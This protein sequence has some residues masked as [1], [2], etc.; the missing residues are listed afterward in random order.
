VSDIPEAQ[1]RHEAGTEIIGK[2]SIKAAI[3]IDWS[4]KVQK[5]GALKLLLT[6][7][8][9][10]ISGLK[11]KEEFIQQGF[12]VEQSLALLTKLLKQDLEPDP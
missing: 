2:R 11:N 6:D 8:K 5:S 9:K 7:V 3:D 12:E 10:V 4:D 1:I